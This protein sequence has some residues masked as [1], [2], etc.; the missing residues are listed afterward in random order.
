MLWFMIV[1]LRDKLL[2]AMIMSVFIQGAMKYVWYRVLRS[3]IKG[4][5]KI[6][7]DQ[8]TTNNMNLKYFY[9]SGAGF[10]IITSGL[11]IINSLSELWGPGTFGI[12]NK[13]FYKYIVVKG[14]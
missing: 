7:K 8:D 1:P 9:V 10:G 13:T 3:S 14:F 5:Q 4:F 6:L 2:Y 12:K 11:A